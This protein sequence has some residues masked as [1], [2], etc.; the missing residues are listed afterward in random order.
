MRRHPWLRI[1]LRF[2]AT[3]HFWNSIGCN[4]IRRGGSECFVNA[5]NP[6]AASGY[7]RQ[8]ADATRKRLRSLPQLRNYIAPETGKNQRKG[9]QADR[10]TSGRVGSLPLNKRANSCDSHLQVYY[11]STLVGRQ[12]IGKPGTNT[13]TTLSRFWSFLVRKTRGREGKKQ[14]NCKSKMWLRDNCYTVRTMYIRG[15]PTKN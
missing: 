14:V 12:R 3:E 4:W 15:G 11:G 10:Q 2:R 9:E 13:L 7:Q 8:V 1:C 5:V 6:W